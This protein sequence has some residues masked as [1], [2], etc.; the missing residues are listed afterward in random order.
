MIL[1][2]HGYCSNSGTSGCAPQTKPFD[3]TVG[4]NSDPSKNQICNAVLYNGFYSCNSSGKYVGLVTRNGDDPLAADNYA[5]DYIELIELLAFEHQPWQWLQPSLINAGFQLKAGNNNIDKLYKNQQY[6]I[7]AR[8]PNN[9]L[10]NPTDMVI[11]ETLTS[12]T[13]FIYD[14]RLTDFAE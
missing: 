14:F 3:L 8:N 5:N 2:P 13:D 6:S 12:G 9:E 1:F 7:L 4:F 10:H 11:W